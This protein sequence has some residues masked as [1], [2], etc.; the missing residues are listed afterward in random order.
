MIHPN[1]GSFGKVLQIGLKA[2]L[3]GV[4]GQIGLKRS[5]QGLLSVVLDGPRRVMFVEPFIELLVHVRVQMS[6]EVLN[7]DIFLE[8]N[9]A[10]GHMNVIVSGA[11]VGNFCTETFDRGLLLNGHILERVPEDISLT[12][13]LLLHLQNVLSQSLNFPFVLLHI[14]QVNFL[15][16]EQILGDSL[17]SLVLLALS[18]L[19]L[20]SEFPVFLFEQIVLP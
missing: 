8:A 15:L 3:I 6:L 14:P 5:L 11:G 13:S 16:F 12:L 18:L 7:G 2:V 4:L 20:E 19:E 1:C 17:I 9:L 10:I